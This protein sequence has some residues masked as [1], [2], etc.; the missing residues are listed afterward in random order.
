ML[1]GA[2]LSETEHPTVSHCHTHSENRVKRGEPEAVVMKIAPFNMYAVHTLK[3]GE[4]LFC[5]R[6]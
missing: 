1:R 2:L 4:G 5:K 6:P 3:D